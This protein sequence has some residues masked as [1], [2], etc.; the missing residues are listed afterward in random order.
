[1]QRHEAILNEIWVKDRIDD[2]LLGR[3]W[4]MESRNLKSPIRGKNQNFYKE[5]GEWLS[6]FGNHQKKALKVLVLRVEANSRDRVGYLYGD[7]GDQRW[8]RDQSEPDQNNLHSTKPQ[9]EGKVR[10]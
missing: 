2:E 7:Q 3:L 6:D 1:M 10:H 8:D 4:K 9:Q 5:Q